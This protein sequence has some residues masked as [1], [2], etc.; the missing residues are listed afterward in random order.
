[1]GPFRVKTRNRLAADYMW[2]HMNFPKCTIHWWIIGMMIATRKDWSS[3]QSLG[4]AVAAVFPDPVLQLA[5][6]ASALLD[7]QNERHPWDP[8]SV[9]GKPG[10][11]YSRCDD[12]AIAESP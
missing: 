12:R 8:P 2:N 7:K 6:T 10:R 3:Q 1:M 5:R 11:G 4:N 9:A